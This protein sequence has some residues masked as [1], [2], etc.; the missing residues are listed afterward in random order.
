MFQHNKRKGSS[1]D[2]IVEQDWGWTS[3]M[4]FVGAMR[5]QGREAIERKGYRWLC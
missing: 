1:I 3:S 2:A 4:G 5:I